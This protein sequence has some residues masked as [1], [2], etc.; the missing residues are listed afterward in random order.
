MGLNHNQCPNKMIHEKK[1]SLYPIQMFD[2]Y[3]A[4]FIQASTKQ[5]SDL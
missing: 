2:E 1:Q 4:L 5:F 3:L